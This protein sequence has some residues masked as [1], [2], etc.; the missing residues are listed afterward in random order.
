MK[1]V[2]SKYYNLLMLS[3]EDSAV[4]KLDVW[5]RDILEDIDE[6]EWNQTCLKAQKQ[7]NIRFKLLKY[8]WLMRIYITPVRLHQAYMSSDI[9]D[10]YTKCLFEKGTLIHCVWGCLNI[11]KFW[12]DVIR[13]QSELF[14][15]K[16]PLKAKLCVLRIYP[17]KLQQSEK[18]TKLID[19]GLLQARRSI[20]LRWR[21]RKA[22]SL[23]L[24]KKEIVKITT[25]DCTLT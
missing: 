2:L 22:P 23:E 11:Q 15:I 4:D 24:W 21:N 10:T 20:A 3:S 16:V 19:Y 8:K 5:R 13:Y 7:T 6:K 9:P 17:R 25:T 12:T 18:N 14:N 1:G